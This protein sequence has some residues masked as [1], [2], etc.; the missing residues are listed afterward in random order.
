MKSARGQAHRGGG[1]GKE[2]S[3]RVVWCRHSF[4]Q[5]AVGFGVR[6]HAGP[7]V[8]VGLDLPRRRHSVRHFGTPLCRRRKGQIGRGNA[9]HFDVEVNAVEQGT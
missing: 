2:L 1:I 7:T 3:P 6:P 5:F 9:L 4:E 8:P